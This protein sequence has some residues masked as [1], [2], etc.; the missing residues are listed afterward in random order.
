MILE[1]HGLIETFSF[2]KLFIFLVML[3]KIH[4]DKIC[5]TIDCHKET[6]KVVI[7]TRHFC[8]HQIKLRVLFDQSLI[9]ICKFLV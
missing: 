7:C 2:D 6:R 4:V 8:M 3:F 5:F 1:K 9:W